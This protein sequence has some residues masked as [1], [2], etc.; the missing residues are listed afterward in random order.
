MNGF[1]WLVFGRDYGGMEGPDRAEGR[2]GRRRMGIVGGSDL[3][4]KYLCLREMVHRVDFVCVD[5]CILS[6]RPIGDT[7]QLS[8]VYTD[9][10]LR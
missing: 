3:V 6:P 1:E 5:D 9:S 10:Y 7:C 4:Y 2:E 8:R